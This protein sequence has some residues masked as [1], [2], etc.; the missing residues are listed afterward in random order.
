MIKKL[1]LMVA[2]AATLFS[3]GQAADT[4]TFTRSTTASDI[5]NLVISTN[6]FFLEKQSDGMGGFT[7]TP[8][9]Y[10]VTC[11]TDFR[12]L[13]AGNEPEYK[14]SWF[15]IKDNVDQ[16]ENAFAAQNGLK[17]DNVT[18][19]SLDMNPNDSNNMTLRTRVWTYDKLD[20]LTPAKAVVG[21]G[22][23]LR[24]SANADTGNT[25]TIEKSG[26]PNINN[27]E[28]V[29]AYYPANYVAITNE[30]TAFT[31]VTRGET[32]TMSFD[33]TANTNISG[34]RYRILL[35]HPAGADPV[36]DPYANATID[37]VT[38][39]DITV[40]GTEENQTGTVTFDFPAET[41]LGGLNVGTT[42]ADGE[43][44]HKLDGANYY[45]LQK[46]N[47]TG[48]DFISYGL[49]FPV[50]EAA[51]LSAG[52]FNKQGLGIYQDLEN[53]IITISD[54]SGFETIYLRNVLGQNVRT[55]KAQNRLDISSL[56]SGI[57]FLQ[58]N[59][60]L[61]QKIVKN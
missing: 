15:P 4:A 37:D 40:T 13:G 58:T 25:L 44:K 43:G 10:T 31:S 18:S 55:F 53:G 32:F 41:T 45:G 21:T 51:T 30:Q 11:V 35:I 27:F 9:T 38:V 8:V 22:Y 59:T 29:A 6:G 19:T 56:P 60:G 3:Y 1:S 57:Y 28:V 50:I 20:V 61:R 5:N 17:T 34:L 39:P 24:T 2:F 48:W 46:Y 47:G 52:N 7:Y 54:V 42:A 33:Y 23:S 12:T 16:S 14:S 36:A 26:I 49:E